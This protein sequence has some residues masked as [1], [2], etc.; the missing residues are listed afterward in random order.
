MNNI[1]TTITNCFNN[2]NAYII[3]C[4]KKID[5]NYKISLVF[6]KNNGNITATI[7]KS[8]PNIHH[9]LLFDNLLEILDSFIKR[10]MNNKDII[11]NENRE[12]RNRVNREMGDIVEEYS[13]INKHL[14][15][16]ERPNKPTSLKIQRKHRK[17]H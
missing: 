15:K 4:L 8:I 3:N 14:K 13:S 12:V 10:Q 17:R 16:F 1:Y 11:L 7:E 9:Q 2:S 5:N 6:S